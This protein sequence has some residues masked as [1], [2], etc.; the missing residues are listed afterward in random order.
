MKQ[1]SL[2]NF[3][4]KTKQF[5]YSQTG[6]KFLADFIMLESITLSILNKIGDW[7]KKDYPDRN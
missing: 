7:I 5:E 1:I 4:Y 3:L 6:I 2:A